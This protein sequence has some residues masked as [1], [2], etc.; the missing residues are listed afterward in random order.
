MV[1]YRL[2]CK[3]REQVLGCRIGHWNKEALD[4][5]ALELQPHLSTQKMNKPVTITMKSEQLRNRR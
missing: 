3:V 5:T 1:A 2:W 4:T